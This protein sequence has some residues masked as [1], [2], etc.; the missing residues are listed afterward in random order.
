MS[1]ITLSQ[2][3][4]VISHLQN[5]EISLVEE[6]TEVAKKREAILALI[7]SFGLT[8]AERRLA[9]QAEAPIKETTIVSKKRDGRVASWQKYAQPSFQNQ[10]MSE[11]VREIL[12]KKPNKG[13]KIAEVI[14]EIFKEDMPRAPYLKA[15]SYISAILAAGARNEEWHKGGRSIYRMNATK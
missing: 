12:S 15:R 6:L 1:T 5:E 13:F 7:V 11:S 2:L 14:S 3:Q 8:E 9:A 10:P 4:V